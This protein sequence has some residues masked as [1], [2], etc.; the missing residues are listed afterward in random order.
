[1][2]SE[3]GYFRL[4]LFVISAVALLVVG[5]VV[6]G[7]GAVFKQTI[8]IETV[9]T[10]SVEG[11]NVG[12]QVKFRGVPIGTVAK[13]EPA[14]WRHRGESL[15]EGVRLGNQIILELAINP[16]TFPTADLDQIR[17]L[18]ARS[19][20]AGLRARVT[21]SGL[22]GPSYVEIAFLDAKDYPPMQLTWQPEQPYVPSAPNAISHVVAADGCG[23]C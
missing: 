12:A 22:T 16:R 15:E 23:K 9:T 17:V 6:L 21:S 5:V 8:P 3:S 4:G 20:D 7:A 18:I 11:L 19:A 1:M 13:I 2:R 14:L 10:E